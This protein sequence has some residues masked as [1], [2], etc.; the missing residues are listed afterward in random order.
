MTE[1]VVLD[2]HDRVAVLS[3][4]RPEVLN[5]IDAV[6]QDA[7]ARR[8]DL[9]E[10]DADVDAVV[11]TGRGR[12]FAAGADINQLR[13]YTAHDGIEGR[14][15]RLYDRVEAMAK[16]TIAAVNGYALGGGCEL[17]MAC[18]IRIG[19]TAAR[20]GLPET[21]LGILPG[22]GG[23]QRLSRLVGQGRALDMVLTGRRLSAEEALAYGLVTEVHPPEDLMDRALQIATAVAGRGPLATRLATSVIRSGGDID[24][25]TGLLIE[26]LAQAVLYGDAQS[27]EGATA[28]IEKRPARFR[29]SR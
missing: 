27:Q 23:T 9:L 13:Q 22:A 5:A 21:M 3:L 14:M 20:F 29:G 8:L 18:D 24:L 6:L 16:P 19:S 11:I 10:D 28:F 1:P 26:R 15:Q 4:N 2:S 12:A 17:A 7:L 25:A